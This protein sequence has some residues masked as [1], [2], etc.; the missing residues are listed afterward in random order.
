[1][2]DLL[3]RLAQRAL[4]T[5]AP[6]VQPRLPSRFADAPGDAA[7]SLLREE[8]A[9]VEAFAPRIAPSPRPAPAA[10]HPSPAPVVR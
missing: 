2:S 4:G 8:A 5:A 6:A 10:A 7:P 1:M 9:E 3:T